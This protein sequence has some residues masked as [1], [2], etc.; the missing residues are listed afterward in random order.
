MSL[1]HWGFPS[2]AGGAN[3]HGLHQTGSTPN[4][5]PGVW[6]DSNGDFATV[7]GVDP[8]WVAA[9]VGEEQHLTLYRPTD[10]SE[11]ASWP[12]GGPMTL[13]VA[14]TGDYVSEPQVQHDLFDFDWAAAVHDAPCPFSVTLLPGN[15]A[16]PLVAIETSIADVD[17]G[18]MS[19]PASVVDAPWAA[20]A[21]DPGDPLFT[22]AVRS[23]CA[24]AVKL[25]PLPH[26]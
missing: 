13:M 2:G 20:S 9:S 6:W 5:N 8:G 19:G 10:P 26:G 1:W 25:T 22:I 14:G 23:D 16:G 24:W 11:Y 15:G 7:G 4:Y 12:A 17:Q 21:G 18:P 3:S